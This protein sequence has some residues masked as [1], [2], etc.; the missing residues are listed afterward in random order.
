MGE[1]AKDGKLLKT[2]TIQFCHFAP[3]H[4]LSL[5]LCTSLKSHACYPA[6]KNHLYYFYC[7]HYAVYDFIH[8]ITKQQT[9]SEQSNKAHITNLAVFK[10]PQRVSINSKSTYPYHNK[11]FI[12]I[13]VCYFYDWVGSCMVLMDMEMGMF[14]KSV[15]RSYT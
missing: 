15:R 6:R 4:S 11:T 8:Q 2:E 14:S 3:R 1:S 12:V 10:R 13:D 7:S 9:K 5:S